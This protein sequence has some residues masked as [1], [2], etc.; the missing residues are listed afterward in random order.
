MALRSIKYSS[1]NFF[2]LAVNLAINTTPFYIF[3][4][5]KEP[6]RVLSTIT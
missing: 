3:T 1:T 2:C 6:R 4:Q 5:Q